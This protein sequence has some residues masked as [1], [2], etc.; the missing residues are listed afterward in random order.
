MDLQFVTVSEVRRIYDTLVADFAKDNDP[1]APAGI[2]SRALLESAVARQWTGIGDHLKYPGAIENAATLLYGVCNDHPFH[3]GNKRTALVSMLVHLDK[4]HLSLFETSQDDLYA[5]IKR[6]AEHTIGIRI[7]K[8]HR[9]RRLPRR[10]A[11][12]EVAAIADFIRRRAAK[13]ERGDKRIT[14]SELRRILE[15]FGFTLKSP[16]KNTIDIVKFEEAREGILVKRTVLREKRIGNIAYPRDSAFVGIGVVKNVRKICHLREEDGI[17][18]AAFY[19]QTAVI[20][21]FINRYRTI[22]RRLARQ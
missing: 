13:I 15:G 10:T 5:M 19:D 22:L 4:N 7:R 6:V 11:D 1:I 14:Y 8:R 9:G 17:D 21:A 20:D 2:R 3:N 16:H 18:S 12:E